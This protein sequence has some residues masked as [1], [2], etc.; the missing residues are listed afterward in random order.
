M[1]QSEIAKTLITVSNGTAAMLDSQTIAQHKKNIQKIMELSGKTE[2]FDNIDEKSDI[3]LKTIKRNQP[4]KKSD[5][6]EN[7]EQ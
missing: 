6:G 7:N 5:E 1:T 4:V 2:I 3:M